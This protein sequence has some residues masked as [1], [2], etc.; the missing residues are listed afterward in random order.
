ME[1]IDQL[2]AFHK[3]SSGNLTPNA[4]A[5]YF[6]L[7]MVNNGTGWKEWFEE[8]DFWLGRTVGIKRR[9]TILSA[10]NLLKQKGFI[11]FERGGTHKPT[12]YKIIP[13]L[14]SSIDSA[15]HSA[16]HS[17]ID[18]AI[19]SSIDSAITSGSPRHKTKTKDKD[20]SAGAFATFWAAYPKKVKKA[21][22]LKSFSKIDPSDDL[23]KVMLTSL[24]KFKQTDQWQKDG[25]QFIPDPSTWLNQ[26]RWEDEISV[27]FQAFPSMSAEEKAERDRQ[28]AEEES[29]YQ[30]SER[31][32]V[33]RELGVRMDAS[34]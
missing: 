29:R 16:I 28:R 22:A 26:H 14:N 23:L 7:F 30:A 18:S 1:F 10:L 13:L 19:D 5:I 34:A 21:V 24:E 3:M 11:D 25:G 17:A 6:E 2:K 32:R 15:I 9:E 27:D 33:F 12:R 8:S 20:I 4:I 31:E